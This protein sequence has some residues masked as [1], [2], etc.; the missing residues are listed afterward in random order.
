[1]ALFQR[2]RLPLLPTTLRRAPVAPL[3]AD[4]GNHR[5][6]GLTELREGMVDLDAGVW[7]RTSAT[8]R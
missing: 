1:M 4:C 2:L 6:V 3:L 8:F 7:L 5:R